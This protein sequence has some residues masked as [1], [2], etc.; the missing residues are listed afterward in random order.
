MQSPA[1]PHASVAEYV[2]D[3]WRLCFDTGYKKK[4]CILQPCNVQLWL[5]RPQRAVLL[6]SACA[7]I[8]VGKKALILD[9]GVY[10][11]H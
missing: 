9:A 4:I 1:T 5:V 6:H 2:A 11:V 7:K 8:K 3:Y 10:E